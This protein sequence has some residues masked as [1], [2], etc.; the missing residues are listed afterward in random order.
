MEFCL[1]DVKVKVVQGIEKD[2]V[3]LLQIAFGNHVGTHIDGPR[4]IIPGAQTLDQ[5]PLESFYGTAVILNVKRGADQPVT[6]QDL[7]SAKP[8]VQT[9]DIVF[10]YTGWDTVFPSTDFQ[11]HHPYLSEDGAQYLAAKKVR[12][13]GI[14]ATSVDMPTA[15]RKPGFT[16]TSLRILLQNKIPVIHWLKNLGSVAGSRVTVAAFPLNF[17]DVDS[18]PARVVALVE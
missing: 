5:F 6:K 11:Y 13:V 15:L 3:N 14:D 4:H 8:S 7:E 1:R 17:R 10:L 16:H 2:G 18:T 12:M 9:G